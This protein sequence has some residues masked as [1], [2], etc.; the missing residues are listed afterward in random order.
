M[1]SSPSFF[2]DVVWPMA[3]AGCPP[4][5]FFVTISV[6]EQAVRER[7]WPPALFVF[8]ERLSQPSS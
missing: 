8:P 6:R 1:T 2:V 7:I 4:R 5:D 3:A